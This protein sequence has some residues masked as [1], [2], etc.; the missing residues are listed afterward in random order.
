MKNG[1]AEISRPRADSRSRGKNAAGERAP[2]KGPVEGPVE[3]TGARPFWRQVLRAAGPG[4]VAMLADTDAG[5]VIT[6]AQSGAVWGDRLLLPNLLLIPFMFMAQELAL[7]L[8]LGTGQGL[9]ELVRRR[10]GRGAALAL[11][12]C[13]GASSFGALVSELAGIAG[14]GAALG[15]PVWLT[16]GG[17]V[18]GLMAVVGTGSYRVVERAAL[19]LG[20]CTLA[21]FVMA[22]RAG[23]EPAR[24]LAAAGEIPWRE[25]GYLWLLAAN[26]GT[27]IIPWALVY[28]Q[29]ASVDKGLGPGEMRAARIET[30]AGVVLCQAITVALLVAASA[31]LGK[32]MEL[33]SV[34][35]IEAAFSATLGPV[36][37]RLIFVL[38]LSGGALV[39]AIVACLAFA[40]AFGE[41]L[42]VR[43]S[44][45]HDPGEAPWFYATIAV[46]LVA[47]GLLVA[48]GVNLVSLAVGAGVANALLLPA[49]LGLLVFLARTA[50][51][52]ALRLA[53]ARGAA[54]GTALLGI[55]AV[56]LVAGLAGVFG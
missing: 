1:E 51:P 8:G 38:G 20:L 11:L 25:P 18:A 56:G 4:L 45:E 35:E 54:V 30:F 50:L 7:R 3:G 46:M 47:A 9:A 44:L 52:P 48:S 19:G 55:A 17:A 42:G 32:G 24:V 39:A 21:F 22:W 26:L 29:S 27:A 53:G 40:W 2:P 13:L 14:A 31:T 23:P 36:A 12:G 34:G 16:V 43:H 41:A 28:Q 49:I 6:I 37:G 5:S 33:G 10:A 15:L